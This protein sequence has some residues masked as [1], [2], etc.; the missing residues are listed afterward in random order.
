MKI[1]K[2]PDY[3]YYQ[4]QLKKLDVNQYL[5]IK[6]SG[7]HG[8]TNYMGLNKESAKILIEFLQSRMKFLED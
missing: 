2:Q 6:I 1:K 3:N 8:S 4:D 7:A 5:N